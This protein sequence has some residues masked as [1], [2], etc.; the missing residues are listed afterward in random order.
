[1]E[2]P[3]GKWSLRRR[4]KWESNTKMDV[5]DISCGSGWEVDIIGSR[6]CPEVSFHISNVKPAG[7]TTRKLGWYII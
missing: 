1:V 2:T 4:R 3:L 6:S 5:G 7:S